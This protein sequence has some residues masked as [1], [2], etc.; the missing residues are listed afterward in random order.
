VYYFSEIDLHFSETGAILNERSGK[1]EVAMSENSITNTRSSQGTGQLQEGN[2]QLDAVAKLVPK[3]KYERDRWATTRTKNVEAIA[4]YWQENPEAVRVLVDPK[5]RRMPMVLLR[6]DQFE[7]VQKLIND[8]QNGQIVIQQDIQILLKALVAAKRLIEDQYK[9]KEPECLEPIKAQMDVLVN[10]S[11]RIQST[12]LVKASPF[13]VEPTP[14][15][16]EEL[17]EAED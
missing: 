14:L 3:F 17:A 1:G 16:A 6:K 15:T 4:E 10:I 8:L 5:L 11:G 13:K 12:V 7:I 9:G 2:A